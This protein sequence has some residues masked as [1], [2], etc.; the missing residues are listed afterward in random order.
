MA[1]KTINRDFIEAKKAEANRK[2][3]MKELSHLI[4]R[5]ARIKKLSSKKGGLTDTDIYRIM[6]YEL[7]ED[8]GH[9]RVQELFEIV[10]D[11]GMVDPDILPAFFVYNILVDPDSPHP[12]MVFQEK[13]E[14]LIGWLKDFAACKIK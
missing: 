8:R 9:M 12:L 3:T 11:S 7:L 14:L 1:I 10:R 6:C 2:E 4:W 5:E 13:G